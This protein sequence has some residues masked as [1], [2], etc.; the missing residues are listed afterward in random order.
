M[1]RDALPNGEKYIRKHRLQKRWHKVMT[2]LGSAVV[3]CTTYALILPAI[4]MERGCQL[5]E[6]THS[7]SCYTQVLPEA[8]RI[9]VCSA[10]TL[11]LHRHTAACY[12]TD[13]VPIC[14]YANYMVHVHDA[15]CYDDEDNFWCPLPTIKEHRHDESCY[16]SAAH[17]HDESC[18]TQER[19]ELI[20]RLHEH[21]DACWAEEEI[22]TCGQEEVPGHRHD[23]S[24]LTV[25][26][27]LVC[28]QPESEGH[29]HSDACRD[30][31]GNLVCGLEESAGHHHSPDCFALHTEFTCG[32]EETDGHRHGEACYQLSRELVCGIESD[33]QH[34]DECYSMTDVLICGEEETPEDL[35]ADPEPVCGKEEIILHRHTEEC[36]DAYGTLICGKIQVLA[37]Q[38]GENCFAVVEP[39]DANA[40]TCTIPEGEGAHT[41]SEDCYDESGALVCT[42][43]ENPGHQH[44]EH[45]YGTWELTCG[46]EEHVH[47]A[48]CQPEQN[49]ETEPE[50]EPEETQPEEPVYYCGLEEHTHSEFCWDEDGNLICELEEHTHTA[51]CLEEP[52]PEEPVYYCGLTEHT[53][54][55]TCWDEDGSLVCELEEHTHTE[56]CTR[57]KQYYCGKTEHTHDET[58]RDEN[59]NLICGLEEHTHTAQCMEEPQPEEPVYYCGL[60]EHTHSETCWDEDGNLICELEEHTHTAQC[61]EEPQPEEP[62]YY[63]GLEEHTHGETCWDEDGNLVCELEEHTHTEDCTRE[64][65]YYCGKTE[66][67]HD[68]TCRD[69]NGNLI[70]GLEEHTHDD[71]C[72]T[73]YF[74][75]VPEHIHD[76]TC[77]DEDGNLI[78]PLMEHTHDELCLAELTE[79]QLKVIE[80][81]FREEVESLEEEG[82]SGEEDITPAEELLQRLQDAFRLGRLSEDTYLDLY[83]RMQKLLEGAYNG[84]AEA[85]IGTNH[86]L[87]Q[88]SGWFSAYSTPDTYAAASDARDAKQLFATSTRTEGDTSP[89]A[90]HQIDEWGGKN[91][92]E[93]DGVYVSK[94]IAGT[95][96]ENVF[97]IT[98]SVQT[99]QR[100]DE[101]IKEPDMA[102]VIVMDISNT[103][104][105][106]FGGAT[107]YAAAMAAAEDF[108]D[109]FAANNSMG[110]SKVGYVAF[111]TDAH[112]IF[113]LQP[114]TNETQASALKNTMRS[115]TGSIINQSGYGSSQKRFTN[116][117]AGLKMARD[118]LA[119]VSN[120]NKFV[121]FL[122]DG[123]PTTYVKSGYTGHMPIH[124][125]SSD[126]HNYIRDDIYPYKPFTYGT[127]YSDRGAVRARQMAAGMKGSGITIFSIGVDVGGQQLQAYIDQS[128]NNSFTTM[129]R[130]G[131]TYE[132]GG[133]GTGYFV[134]WLCNSIGS[135][136]YYDSTNVEGLKAAYSQIFA[137]IKQTIETAT[138]ADWVAEDPIPAIT[139]DEIEF[140]GMYDRSGALKPDLSGSHD[141]NGENKASFDTGADTIHWDLKESGY[142]TQRN[143][144]TT[145][146]TYNLK[147]RVRLKNEDSQFVE[148]KIYETNGTTTLQYRV[149]RNENGTISISEQKTIEFPIPSVHGF[150]ADL[151]FQKKDNHGNTLPGAEFTLSH[152]PKCNACHGDGTAVN[153]PDAVAISGE[154]GSV[155]FTGIPS[156]HEYT[157]KE[158]KIPQ[159]Y[160]SDGTQY[161][162][163]VAYDELTVTACNS[164]G[165]LVDWDSVVVN[166]A[167]YELPS[168]GGAGTLPYTA[169]GTLLILAAVYLLYSYKKRRKEARASD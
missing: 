108:L 80:D 74:C 130:T 60:T 61:L 18:Y 21:T 142:T 8:K 154:D 23:D 90:V 71:S 128:A 111:N 38:H 3:F 78:C 86:L 12:G 98:L 157:L 155:T 42:L 145:I 100:I 79:E 49:L 14:G 97:D 103:M 53:H 27:S 52:Q 51:Q 141:E 47:T 67:T 91:V 16:A 15:A 66:H 17:V 41:H 69:E 39:A 133:T 29:W 81:A 117:E 58:C 43:E 164:A 121:I 168:T 112:K 115:Q 64:K 75:G 50:T 119:G 56:T 163:K 107:R 85:C 1:K 148:K 129:D 34:T 161:A 32:Q 102:V 57:E 92:N 165:D 166:N 138:D 9:P 83:T 136:Y 151:T 26:E 110:I 140:I 13:N 68:E 139:P 24:C 30:E 144:N 150:L 89:S 35:P 48:Q 134:S 113:D 169:G 109:N 59:G 37:H 153:L 25:T 19:G 93:D 84:F 45:C 76:E 149:V 40:L 104:N 101:V 123:F 131:N 5:P 63:C 162:V 95:D 122:S 20:C 146:Y 127:N 72:T 132:I 126:T 137:T 96:I 22:L 62:V 6:H 36:F 156:G 120:S 105:S 87:L 88:A 125:V 46:M 160:S 2:V 167:Y 143:G 152:A 55:E 82:L 114:C 73:E 11:E 70:C 4:T 124:N 147:Y 118:M 28:G 7:D 33:H 10:E 65:Q 116:M 135:G 44:T 77:F 106:D 31:S 99:P 54:N 158:T 159:G 94:T